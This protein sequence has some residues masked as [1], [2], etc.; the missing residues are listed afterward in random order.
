MT[1][2]KTPALT[3]PQPNAKRQDLQP[4][5]V[6]PGGTLTDNM[7]HPISDDQNSL[8]AGSLGPTLLE[9]HFLREKLHHFDHERI[10]ERIVHAPSTPP[11]RCSPRSARRHPPSCAFPPSPASA[12]ARTPHATS[13]A[14]R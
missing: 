2:P 11:R 4:D 10:P 6:N 3:D 5:T 14:S 9:D 13:A 12:A 7:G 8:K 1:D